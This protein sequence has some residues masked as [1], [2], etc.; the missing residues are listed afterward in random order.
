MGQNQL[1]TRIVLFTTP[2][3]QGSHLWLWLKNLPLARNYGSRKGPVSMLVF[4]ARGGERL[5]PRTAA[6]KLQ[7][8]RR[9]V[10]GNKGRAVWR[11]PSRRK[12]SLASI[13]PRETQRIASYVR[14]D[15]HRKDTA[16]T[17][18]ATWWML[19]YYS[20]RIWA[21]LE[22]LF[23]RKR[24]SVTHST[25][26][27]GLSRVQV[28]RVQSRGLKKSRGHD[29]ILFTF[30]TGNSSLEPL[31]EGLSSQIHMDLSFRFAAGIEQCKWGGQF[32]AWMTVFCVC[33]AF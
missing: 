25:D 31:L 2:R 12:K 30:V 27:P 4:Q 22:A 28:F 11:R 32:F 24:I 14:I 5:Q 10:T 33:V 9:G 18:W 19:L 6:R 7:Q 29:L 13:F 21:L 20:T 1:T 8:R 23:A 15:L 3:S 17:P 26:G 16:I